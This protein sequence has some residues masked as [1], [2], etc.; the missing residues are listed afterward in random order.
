MAFTTLFIAELGDKTQLAVFSLVTETRSP[1]AVF[2]GASLA[3]VAVTLIGVVFGGWV[4]RYVPTRYLKFAAGL[5]FVGIGSFVLWQAV[6]ELI[7]KS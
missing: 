5:M 2:I 4:A 7:H 1:W 3:L 6:T